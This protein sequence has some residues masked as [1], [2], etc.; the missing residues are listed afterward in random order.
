MALTA[1]GISSG[2]A[3][4]LAR[5]FIKYLCSACCV[6]G[7]VP[8]IHYPVSWFL[9][10]KHF[11]QCCSGLSLLVLSAGVHT[12]PS[13]TTLSQPPWL[14]SVCPAAFSSSACSSSLV[15]HEP[16]PCP[17]DRALS[18]ASSPTPVA[19]GTLCTPATPS[20][21]SPTHAFWVSP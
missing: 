5:L 1:C 21:V 15:A 13:S 10:C 6:P 17:M 3:R 4:C 14:F 19:S 2:K 11:T 16:C 20:P 12:P 7:P 8:P 18:W 9:P